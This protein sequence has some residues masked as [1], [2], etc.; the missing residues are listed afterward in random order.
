MECF[1]RVEHG[2]FVKM[3]K[4]KQTFSHGLFFSILF[5]HVIEQKYIQEMRVC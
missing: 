4:S 1:T 5:V 3:K 2:R